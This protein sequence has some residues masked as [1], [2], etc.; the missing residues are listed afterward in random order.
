MNENVIKREKKIQKMPIFKQ[1]SSNIYL[2]FKIICW[3]KEANK[4]M[5]LAS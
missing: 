4:K 2:D 5:I 1:F 3:K